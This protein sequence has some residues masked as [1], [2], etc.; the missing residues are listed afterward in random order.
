MRVRR[1]DDLG[2][3]NER[4]QSASNSRITV[5]GG[6]RLQTKRTA[7]KSG[8]RDF[9]SEG[10]VRPQGRECWTENLTENHE[11]PR[12]GDAHWGGSAPVGG[13]SAG[14]EEDGEAWMVERCGGGGEKVRERESRQRA[15]V[16]G[17]S[18]PWVAPGRS[19]GQ[20]GRRRRRRRQER[21]RAAGGTAGFGQTG[22]DFG[23]R[24]R[25]SAA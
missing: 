9:R 19:S 25:Q 22:G 18:G 11:E 14:V 10:S 20:Q 6:E 15:P 5:D 23:G 16:R 4:R 8:G 3:R 24:K 2:R 1:R 21:V 12:P 13:L 17:G 7:L